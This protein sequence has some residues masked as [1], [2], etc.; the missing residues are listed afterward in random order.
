MLSKDQIASVHTSLRDESPLKIGSI[1][2]SIQRAPFIIRELKVFGSS[3]S[4]LE[5]LSQIQGVILLTLAYKSLEI[6]A[7]NVNSLLQDEQTLQFD[8]ELGPSFSDSTD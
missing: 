5:A 1:V 8:L 2:I 7:T 6:T 3:L 4:E